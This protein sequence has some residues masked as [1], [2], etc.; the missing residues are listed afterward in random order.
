M[1]STTGCILGS[2]K[3]EA[4]LITKWQSLSLPDR[5]IWKWVMWWMA[6]TFLSQA[7]NH[8]VMYPIS[9]VR[10]AFQVFLKICL[11]QTMGHFQVL[12]L[13]FLNLRSELRQDFQTQKLHIH[14]SSNYYFSLTKK[15]HLTDII[16][17]NIT[18]II[19]ICRGRNTSESI[20]TCGEKF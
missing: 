14:L 19:K 6:V 16:S 10:R 8:V 15:W 2:N 20:I 11:H 18:D 13:T 3:L 9:K 17:R 5:S 12:I 1:L 7:T 4:L